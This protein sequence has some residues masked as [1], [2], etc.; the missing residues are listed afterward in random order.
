[1]STHRQPTYGYLLSARREDVVRMVLRDYRS[2][3]NKYWI[4]SE[5]YEDA[6]ACFCDAI[7]RHLPPGSGQLVVR[8]VQYVVDCNPIIYALGR[9]CVLAKRVRAEIK[10]AWRV[11]LNYVELLVLDLEEAGRADLVS[12]LDLIIA[13]LVACSLRVHTSSM[14]KTIN[15]KRDSAPVLLGTLESLEAIVD[16]AI[17]IRVSTTDLL[18]GSLEAEKEIFE[19]CLAQLEPLVNDQLV[20]TDWNLLVN[21]LEV[22]ALYKRTAKRTN[23]CTI[24]LLR[25]DIHFE[26]IS[27][28]VIEM[29]GSSSV[30]CRLIH[31][32]ADDI[33]ARNCPEA[34][35]DAVVFRRDDLVYWFTLNPVQYWLSVS[36]FRLPLLGLYGRHGIHPLRRY[37]SPLVC[38]D[39]PTYCHLHIEEALKR[40]PEED[41]HPHLT[42]PLVARS[43]SPLPPCGCQRER[44]VLTSFTAACVPFRLPVAHLT[45]MCILATRII[46]TLERLWWADEDVEWKHDRQSP[47]QSVMSN[48]RSNIRRGFRLPTRRDRASHQRAGEGW[49]PPC[50]HL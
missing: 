20:S 30:R 34:T 42:E 28:A 17:S 32:L 31:K 29:R 2:L 15:T 1:M 10:A 38:C 7:F 18:I 13:R 41:I 47:V 48:Y 49:W 4:V 46:I 24:T 3:V 44:R 37:E 8:D 26:M 16:E 23:H 40:P 36:R 5:F 22:R 39:R 25:T 6:T 12:H 27:K 50:P 43:P 9:R 14:S 21:F 45:C 35:I 19:I 33:L 11:L